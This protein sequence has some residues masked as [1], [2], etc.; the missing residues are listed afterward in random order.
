M[1]N[2]LRWPYAREAFMFNYKERS[3]LFDVPHKECV[4][5]GEEAP[6]TQSRRLKVLPQMRASILIML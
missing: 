3:N 4:R 2:T 1:L 5:K 6:L